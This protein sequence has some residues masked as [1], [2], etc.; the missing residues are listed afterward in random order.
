MCTISTDRIAAG[1]TYCTQTKRCDYEE[2][3]TQILNSH[4][5]LE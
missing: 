1:A 2:E 3:K 4:G 5:L